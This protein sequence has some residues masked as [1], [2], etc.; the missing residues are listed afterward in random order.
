M[1]DVVIVGGGLA[2]LSAGWRLRHWDTVLLESGNRVGGRIRSERRGRYWLNWGG[3][4]F[5]GPGSSTDALLYEVGIAAAQ[6]P[7]SLAGLSMNG[8]LLLKGPDR[9]L[10]VPHPDVVGVPH[11]ARSRPASRWAHRSRGT[12]ASCG[13]APAKT[14]R[15]GSSGSTTSRTTAASPTSSATS[16][17]TPRRCSDRRSPGRP[18]DPD[19]ISAGAGI[20]YF[21]LVLEH[22]PGPE[23]G[24][25]RRPVHPDRG[26]RRRRWATGCSSA[27]RSQ[28][29][30]HTKR[31]GR[32]PV[33]AGRGR[34]GGRGA[35]RRAGHAGHREP[36]GSPSTCPADIRDALGKVV[37][38]PYVSAAFLT[39]ETGPAAVGRRVRHRH[40]EAVVQHR[41]QPVEH[42]PGQRD[43]AATGRQ[44][45][46]VL[47]G[48]PGAHPAAEDRRGDRRASTLDDLDQ[49][50]GSGF[51][52]SVVEAS[53]R[54]GRPAR[55]TASRAGASCSR[56]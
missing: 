5:A 14:R 25:R 4:V 18:A 24:H 11:R 43:D 21:S 27:P 1:K 28:E 3:H 48:R 2:G 12:P 7:G 9:D 31:L 50:L 37:Y 45:H 23:P 53:V 47:P 44:H 41:A 56:P 36:T 34:P 51:G 33:P 19:E 10:P 55:P 39:D 35:L 8:K 16:R 46:D 40:A 49:V 52:G 38:G 20:G 42:R 26:H 22:R 6:V 30:V 13:S 32:R 29:I 54:A 17:T 15:S